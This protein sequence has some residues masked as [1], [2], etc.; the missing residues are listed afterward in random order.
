MSCAPGCEEEELQEGLM[1]NRTSGSLQFAHSIVKYLQDL[2][3]LTI[4]LSYLREEASELVLSTERLFSVVLPHNVSN[5]PI[6][7]EGKAG[8]H[9]LL[10]LVAQVFV[11]I[12]QFGLPLDLI[13]TL[14]AVNLGC[15]LLTSRRL[16][17]LRLLDTEIEKLLSL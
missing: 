10:V 17:E 15:G 5:N 1:N 8:V 16:L 14:L 2:F 3:V 6:L 7:D 4:L 12:V 11:T 9:L 13:V